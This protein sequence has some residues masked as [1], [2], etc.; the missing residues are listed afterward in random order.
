MRKTSLAA[1]FEFNTEAIH[2]TTQIYL[3][4]TLLE[5]KLL[6]VRG[7]LILETFYELLTLFLNVTSFANSNFE[8]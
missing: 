3:S 7:N 1:I 4:K 8:T 2:D 6:F 5:K